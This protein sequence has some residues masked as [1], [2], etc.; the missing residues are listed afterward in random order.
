MASLPDGLIVTAPFAQPV[1]LSEI[2]IT[3]VADTVSSAGGL[4]IL[5][6]AAV[7]FVFP[8]A[9]PVANPPEVMEAFAGARELQTT[10]EVI[11]LDPPLA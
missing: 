5:L 8:G 10:P 11:W 2:A 1:Q 9:R 6:K 3:G 4:T 7:I